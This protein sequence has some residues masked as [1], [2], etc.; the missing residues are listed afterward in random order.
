MRQTKAWKILLL[1]ALFAAVTIVAGAAARRSQAQS[2]LHFG[3][4]PY[5][6]PRVIERI[7]APIGAEFSRVLSREI[8]FRTASSYTRFMKNLNLQMYDIVFVQPFDYVE[9]AD[10]YGYR[11]L[12]TRDKRLP[13]ILV[14]KSGTRLDGIQ[15]LRGRTIGLPPKVAAISYMVKSHL[16]RN[17]LV[18]GRDVYIKHFRSHGSCMHNVLVGSVVACGTA[19]PAVRVFQSRMKVRLQV[20]ARTPSISNS[21]F[22]VHPRVPA[23]QVEALRRAILSWPQSAKG[24]ELLKGAKVGA[25][26]AVDDAQYDEV[27][28]MAREFRR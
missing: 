22:A 19:P 7:Y 23:A 16:K 14:V 11:P 12:A 25:F 21:L 2:A 13:A 28:R 24:R 9:I 27:R 1:F 26:V 20:I 10:R 8:L 17:G 18:P 5:I 4:F 3:V 6:A 15:S